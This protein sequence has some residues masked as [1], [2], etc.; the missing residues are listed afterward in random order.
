MD[1]RIG[2]RAAC[3]VFVVVPPLVLGVV[4]GTLRPQLV[5]FVGPFARNFGALCYH[6][7]DFFVCITPFK[8]IGETPRIS[9]LLPL[10]VREVHGFARHHF[11]V[12]TYV[13]P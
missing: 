12:T 13:R 2:L 11:P 9:V 3:T 6:P 7:N 8:F 1:V 4:G 5:V 10:V